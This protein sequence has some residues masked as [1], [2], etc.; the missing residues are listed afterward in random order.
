ML[1]F[2][3]ELKEV[4]LGLNESSAKKSSSYEGKVSEVNTCSEGLILK[5]FPEHLKYAF[6]E[7]RKSKPV[8][9]SADLIEHIE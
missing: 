7:A 6:L 8:I 1:N 9:I 2:C 5:E 4:V 3:F